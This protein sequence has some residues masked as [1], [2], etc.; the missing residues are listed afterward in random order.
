MLKVSSQQLLV[1][2]IF[3]ICFASFNIFLE[4]SESLPPLSPRGI[5][6]M[7]F[8]CIYFSVNLFNLEA[9]F[10]YI[11]LFECFLLCWSASFMSKLRVFGFLFSGV[12]VEMASFT[13]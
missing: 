3:E 13:C 6:L 12:N 11:I 4:S 9:F 10:C 2:L 8:S 5:E 1:R 7:F